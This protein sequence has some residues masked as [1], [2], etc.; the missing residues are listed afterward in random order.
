MG[1]FPYSQLKNKTLI[2]LFSAFN[3]MFCKI[4]GW[5]KG[6]LNWFMSHFSIFKERGCSIFLIDKCLILSY[7]KWVSNDISHKSL[8]YF[9]RSLE[10]SY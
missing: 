4:A 6:K 10:I 9:K 8:K 2:P 7:L 3:L 1:N 5:I